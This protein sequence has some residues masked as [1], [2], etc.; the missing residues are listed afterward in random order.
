VLGL[1]SAPLQG[2]Y[3]MTKAAII[4]MTKTLAIELGPARIRVN[5]IAPGLVETRFAATLT[6]TPELRKLFED[7]TAWGQIAKPDDIA[8]AALFLASDDSAYVT[9][10]TLAVDAGYSI[11]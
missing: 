8:G 6:D 5:A 4:S 7:R 9:G 2:V 10:Q 1:Q 3:G 11:R